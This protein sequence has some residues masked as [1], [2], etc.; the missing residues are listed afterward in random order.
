MLLV[1]DSSVVAKWFFL[2]PLTE[3]ALAVRRD[4]A[5]S[6]VELIVPKLLLVEVSN[7]I[8]KKQRVGLITEEEGTSA[9]ANL[10]ALEIHT[11]DPQAI[12]PRAYSLARL[13][14]RTVYDALYLALA[15]QMGARFITA[16]LRLYNAVGSSLEF[17]DYLAGYSRIS[18]S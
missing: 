4:W 18:S 15:E 16:D 1:I 3:Q 10:L 9:I 5:L 14:D 12:L 11:V 17:V 8:W 13:F 6:A 2:E 7:I